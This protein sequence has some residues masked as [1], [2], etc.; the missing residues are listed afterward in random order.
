LSLKGFSMA[1]AWLTV[2]QNVPWSEVVRNAP[3]VAAGAKKLWGSVAHKDGVDHAA[4]LEEQSRQ[5][6]EHLTLANLQSQIATLQS[7]AGELQQRLTESTDLITSLAEQNAQLIHR[8]DAIRKRMARFGAAL[9]LV[10]AAA[11]AALWLVL[12]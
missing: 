5:P 11:G 12:R 9:V 3:K 1:I 6:P 4:D 2:L 7:V 10:G 8:I